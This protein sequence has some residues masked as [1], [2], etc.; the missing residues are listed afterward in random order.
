MATRHPLSW[1]V[2][3]TAPD[4]NGRPTVLL[5][6]AVYDEADDLLTVTGPGGQRE[7]TQ[8]R[9][10][11]MTALAKLVLGQMFRKEQDS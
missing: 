3:E 2:V 8:V 4:R 6:R 9:G 1:L 7:A 11:S 5:A 10:A